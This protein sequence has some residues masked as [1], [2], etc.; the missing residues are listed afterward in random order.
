MMFEVYLGFADPGD[1]YLGRLL[2][3]LLPNEASYDA[4]LPHFTCGMENQYISEAMNL[5]FKGMISQ[6][7]DPFQGRNIANSLSSNTKA[8][9]LQCLADLVQ[10]KMSP[11]L[12]LSR[13][14]RKS[15]I[16]R[17]NRTNFQ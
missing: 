7:I 11:M 15:F 12:S 16:C 2:S 17:R 9:I 8:L 3:G 13:M 5:C 4:L 14:Y 10:P 1:Q 6:N